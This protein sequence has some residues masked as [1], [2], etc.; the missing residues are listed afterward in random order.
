MAVF[1][2]GIDELVVIDDET[3]GNVAMVVRAADIP[4]M[5]KEMGWEKPRTKRLAEYF[6]GWPGL[7]RTLEVLALSFQVAR[8]YGYAALEQFY[9]EVGEVF[10]EEN[11]YEEA[12]WVNV[13]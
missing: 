11:E 2:P 4:V 8:D 7:D 9:M 1:V 3:W 12:P 13:A 6:Y 5:V 10:A